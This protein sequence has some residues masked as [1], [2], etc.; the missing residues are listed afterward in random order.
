MSAEAIVIACATAEVLAVV[1]AVIWFVRRM[2]GMRD[3]VFTGD[4]LRGTA[5]VTSVDRSAKWWARVLSPTTARYCSP[6]RLS[7]W[8]LMRPIRTSFVLISPSRSGRWPR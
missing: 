5:Q 3:P 4:T 8:S 1:I 2:R 6:A 7:R